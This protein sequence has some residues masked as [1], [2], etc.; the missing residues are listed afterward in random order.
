[1]SADDYREAGIE[2][3][4]LSEFP[5]P[6]PKRVVVEIPDDPSLQAE[7][8]L[9]AWRSGRPIRTL[10]EHYAPMRYPLPKA[11]REALQTEQLERHEAA[12]GDLTRWLAD[13]GGST[14]DYDFFRFGARYGY[15]ILGVD[16]RGRILGPL[17]TPLNK[18]NGPRSGLPQISDR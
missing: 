10:A 2:P 7:L 4:D 12:T 16:R 13:H 14:E 1:M 8:R 17:A 3:P 9:D 6:Y 18:R 11:D 5:G 15:L